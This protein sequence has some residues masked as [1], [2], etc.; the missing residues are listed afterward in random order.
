M[1]VYRPSRPTLPKSCGSWLNAQCAEILC[2]LKINWK[3]VSWTGVGLWLYGPVTKGGGR[4]GTCPI[5]SGLCPITRPWAPSAIL[6]PLPILIH[7]LGVFNIDICAI[8]HKIVQN[9]T[10]LLK[11]ARFCSKSQLE[12]INNLGVMD[13]SWVTFFIQGPIAKFCVPIASNF[14][15]T[16]LWLS[17]VIIFLPL[18]DL[19][20]SCLFVVP[21]QEIT[22]HLFLAT[23][24]HP[25]S[26][27]SP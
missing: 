5:T 13:L 17:L 8:W 26:G 15:A 12:F 11:I 23:T 21:F 19:R 14:L 25:P 27:P 18:F 22:E 7:D 24:P 2:E 1:K 6:T 9:H 20:Q 4:W 10:N 3:R 16:G